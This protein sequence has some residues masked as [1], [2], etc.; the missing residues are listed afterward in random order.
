MQ[1]RER[2]REKNQSDDDTLHHACTVDTMCAVPVFMHAA[3]I[4]DVVHVVHKARNGPNAVVGV[5]A[6]R[7]EQHPCPFAGVF[8]A[9][10]LHQQRDHRQRGV[11]VDHG[12]FQIDAFHDA[13]VFLAVL[14]N[15]AANLVQQ[16]NAGVFVRRFQ[17]EAVL[18]N[19]P[20][21]S[22]AFPHA[23][24]ERTQMRYEHVVGQ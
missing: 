13:V 9:P 5:H 22:F 8:A 24:V 2:G 3:G 11:G 17:G 16:G 14:N 18:M 4:Q 21:Q 15:V 19:V 12:G 1:L 10:S 23:G 6:F 7:G 20:L